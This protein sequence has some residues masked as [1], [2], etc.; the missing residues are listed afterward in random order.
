MSG[1]S[2]GC[3]LPPSSSSPWR[4]R[5]SS[6]TSATPSP[7]C[8]SAWSSAT[9]SSRGS[10]SSSETGS[11]C[12]RRS[13]SCPFF[14]S[15]HSPTCRSWWRSQAVLSMVPDLF[16][17][18]RHSGA[19]AHLLQ[20]L[21]V[22]H[23]SGPRA[24]RARPRRAS[25]DHAAVYVVALLAQFAFDF[26]WTVLRDRVI[27]RAPASSSRST[28]TSGSLRFDAIL[29]PIAFAI[30]LSRGRPAADAAQR[31]TAGLAARDPL[32]RP[33]RAV[34][35]GAR[36]PARV[37]RHRDAARRRR[38][39]R[40]PVHRGPLALGRRA[41]ARHGRRAWSR[42]LPPPG[43]RVRRAA[44][45]RREDRDPQG[46]PQQ[47]GRPHR[48]RVRG[49]EDPHDRGPVHAGP[50]RRTS[51]TRRRDRPL[52]PRAVGRYRLPGRPPRR[53][54]SRSSPASSSRP[55]PSTR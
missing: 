49:D 21:L 50:G 22:L 17:G 10:G 55:T 23:R 48:Q 45:R 36:A 52:V 44:A 3:P 30:T 18:S 43:A 40:R 29:A 4:L 34:H 53:A 8:S 25:L 31:R 13:P 51:G 19:G 46:D 15:P 41:R 27:D 7:C 11:W 47:A 37:P 26:A 20:R 1:R 6:R 54:R 42:A 39:V 5:W 24:C 14:S 35:R 12:R 28:T 32:A 38:R 16:D 33:P 2:S 9:P